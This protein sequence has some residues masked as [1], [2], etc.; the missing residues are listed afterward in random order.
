MKQ[1]DIYKSATTSKTD[2]GQRS[3]R[4]LPKSPITSTERS[5][6]L[7]QTILL[8]IIYYIEDWC[9]YL[10]WTTLLYIIGIK[11]RESFLRNRRMK[12]DQKR[13]RKQHLGQLKQGGLRFCTKILCNSVYSSAN[14]YRRRVSRQPSSNIYVILEKPE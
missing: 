12:C 6:T 5:I 13:N 9:Q 10:L 8:T 1:L 14:I 11:D 2:C 3:R 4:Q 7:Q